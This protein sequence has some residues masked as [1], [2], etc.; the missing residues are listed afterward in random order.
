MSRRTEATV[1]KTFLDTLGIPAKRNCETTLLKYMHLSSTNVRCRICLAKVQ[2]VPSSGLDRETKMYNLRLFFVRYWCFLLK[3]DDIVR[4]LTRSSAL[5]VWHAALDGIRTHVFLRGTQARLRIDDWKRYY[6]R[7][8]KNK[9]RAMRFLKH[10]NVTYLVVSR[11]AL[12]QVAL[13]LS[14][15][16]GASGVSGDYEIFLKK[17]FN[18]PE[19]TQTSSSL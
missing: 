6:P 17:P 8:S 1:I 12:C 5:C 13:T 15:G 4:L 2:T 16:A 18:Y 3:I 9:P 7:K 11:E 19:K 10:R 14:A